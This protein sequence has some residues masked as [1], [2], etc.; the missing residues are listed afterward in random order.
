MNK[1]RALLISTVSFVALFYKQFVALNLGIFALLVWLLLFF[2][3]TPKYKT[4]VYW[5]L[6]VATFI[7]AFSFSWYGD[8]LSFFALACSLLMLGYKA[9]FPRLRII[10]FPLAAFFNYATFIFRAPVFNNWLWPGKKG[11]TGIVKKIVTYLLIPGFFV[12]IFLV[13]YSNSSNRFASYFTFDWNV[14]LAQLFFLTILGFFLMF[15]YFHFAVP[16]LLIAYNKGLR[17]NFSTGYH[18]NAPSRGILDIYSQ[19]RSG[20]IT[21]ILLNALL[22]FFIIIYSLEQFI[23]TAAG[24]ASGSL[25]SEVHERVYILIFSIILAIIIIMIYFRG[26]LNFD[27]HA[28]LLKVLSI[29]WICLNI[30]LVAVVLA[31]NIQYVQVYGLT[32]KRIGVFVFLLLSIAGLLT[33]YH[34]LVFIK[35]NTFLLTRMFWICFSVLVFSAIINWSWVVTKYNLANQAK[36]DL[37]Y[38]YSLDYNKRLLYEKFGDAPI[39]G[40]SGKGIKAIVEAEQAKPFLS[41]KLYYEFLHLN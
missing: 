9:L 13:V 25:S 37:F 23:E 10:T 18:L 38:L 2:I 39:N 31:K 26:M 12:S 35:T 4:V 32:F 20:E 36:P 8:F 3:L 14:D 19:R 17:D 29:S 7:S 16:K 5:W 30:I 21:L 15:S 33:T 28:R 24:S 40:T 34:K 6:S 11:S 22:I 41:K 27:K 1:N